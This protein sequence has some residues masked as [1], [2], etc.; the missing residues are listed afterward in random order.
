M[1]DKNTHKKCKI[2]NFKLVQPSTFQLKN[3]LEKFNFAT[4]QAKWLHSH[5]GAALAMRKKWDQC[6]TVHLI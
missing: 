3:T 5:T 6:I 4:C 2:T 1:D